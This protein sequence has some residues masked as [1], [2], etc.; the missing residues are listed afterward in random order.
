[1]LSEHFSLDELVFSQT[2]AR[3]G[4]DNTPTPEHFRNMRRLC[5]LLEDVRDVVGTP[6]R[7][8]SG[9]RCPDLNLAIGGAKNSQ[10]LTGC[11]ADI[12]CAGVSTQEVIEIIIEADLPYDQLIQEYADSATGGWVHIS[13]PNDPQDKPRKDVLIIDSKGTR[14]YA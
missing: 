11:A 4:I 8:T 2:A 12:K 13:V 5:A 1:M 14:G 3:K 9:Y 10:H 7:V 6:V